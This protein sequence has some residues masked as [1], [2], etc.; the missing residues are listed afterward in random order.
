MEVVCHQIDY[1]HVFAYLRH[2]IRSVDSG[3][4]GGN[5]NTKQVSLRLECIMKFPQ[6]S[7]IVL[8]VSWVAWVPIAV[9]YRVLRRVFPK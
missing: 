9:T 5:C 4:T 7:H 1:I 6:Q 3:L 2:I 8:F